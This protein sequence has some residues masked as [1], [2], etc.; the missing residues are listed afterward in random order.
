MTILVQLFALLMTFFGLVG[1]IY[2]VGNKL[3]N[4]LSFEMIDFTYMIL[5]G[6]VIMVLLEGV[7]RGENN[8][9]EPTVS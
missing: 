1:G 2:F 8:K 4:G 3:W 6:L 7:K 5:C 9:E